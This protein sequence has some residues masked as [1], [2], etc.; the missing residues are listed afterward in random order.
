MKRLTTSIF[1]MTLLFISLHAQTD[2][3]I[4]YLNSDFETPDDQQNWQSLPV[5]NSIKWIYATGGNGFEP[6]SAYSGSKNALFYWSANDPYIRTLVSKAIDLSSAKKPELSFAHAMSESVFGQDNMVLLFRA[7]STG[8]WDT[9]EKFTQEVPNWTL[10]TY[11]I[12][13]Y[14]TKYLTSQFY[15]AFK[16][17]SNSGDGVCV[18]KVM[19][20]EKDII[21]RYPKTV[22]VNQINHSLIPR[23]V[24]DIPL[25]RIDINIV[26]NTDPAT[27]K[28]LVFKSLSSHDSLFAANG[29]ELVAT[30]D[31]VYKPTALGGASYK[32]GSPT[33]ITSGTVTFTNINFNLPT[34]MSSIWL[35][36]D[37]KSTAPHS[38]IVDFRM[39]GNSILINTSSGANY[40]PS[41]PVSPSGVNHVEEAIVLSDFETG[42][43]GWTFTGPQ[44]DFEIAIPMGKVAHISR[45]PDCA[46]SG[47]KVLGTDL[48]GDGKYLANIDNATAYYA[49]SPVANLKYYANVKLY[50]MKWLSFEAN[51]HAV[52]EVSTD[53]AKT[54]IKIWDSKTEALIPDT[55]W[56]EHTFSKNF[57]DLAARKPWVQVRFGI[58]SSDNSF[59]YA[60]WNIDNFA[61]T[62]NF[63]SN[64]IGITTLIKPVNDCLNPGY[65]SVVITV[66]NFAPYPTAATLPVFFSIDGTTRINDNIPG[67]IPVDGAV[68]FTFSRPANISTPNLYNKFIVDLEVSGDEDPSNDTIGRDLFIQNSLGVPSFEKFETGGGYWFPGGSSPTWECILPE[69]GGFPPIPQSPKAWTL[70]PYGNYI[71][72]DTSYVISSCYDLISEDSLLYEMKLWIDSEEGKD[73][74]AVEY[75]VDE[76]NTWRLLGNNIHGWNWNWYNVTVSSLG[77]PG[78]SAQ[79]A[80]WKTVR[81]VLPAFLNYEPKVKFRVKWASDDDNNYRGVAFDDVRIYNA[82]IDIGVSHIDSFANRCQ[83]LNPEEVTVVVKNFGLNSLKQNDTIIVAY[84]FNLLKVETDTFKLA[85]DLLPGQSI[86]HTF[87]TRIETLNPG[88][89]HIRAYTLSEN[90]PWFYGDN[91]DSV[92]VSFSVFPNPVTSLIDTIQTHLPDTVILVTTPNSTYDYWWNG[93]SGSNTYNV[94]RDGWQYLKVT[95]TRG[96]GCTS[97]DSTNVELLFHDIGTD[98]LLHPVDNCGFGKHEYPVV[99]VRNFGTDSITAGQ[100]IVVVYQMNGEVPVSDTIT[101]GSTLHSG[102][103]VNFTFNKGAIDLSGAGTYNFKIYTSYG[104]DTIAVND[105]ITRSVV[106]LGRP[107]VSLGSD[108]TVEALSHTLDAGSGYESYLWDNNVTTRTREVTESGSYWVQVFDNK[109]CDNFDTAYVRLKIRDIS[110][111]GFNSPVSACTFN[112]SEP[113]SLKIYN[114]GTDTIASGTSIAVSYR[115]EEGTRINGNTTLVQQLLPGSFVLYTFGGTVDMSNQGDFSM[116][117]TAKIAGDLRTSNDTSLVTIYRY[118]GPSI[119]FGL[120]ETEYVE[121]VSLVIDAGYSPYYS[122]QWQDTVTTHSYTATTSGLFHVKA[123]DIRTQCFDR[124]TVMVFLIYGDVGITWS[125]MPTEGCAGTYENV[126]VRVQNLGPSVIGSS[127][128]IYVACD[129]NGTRVTIDTLVRTGN[130]NPGATLEMQ[131]SGS[132]PVMSAGMSS[133]R[134]Y[135]MYNK[136]K[137]PENDTLTIGFDAL[138][139]PEVNFGDVDG[140]L[141]VD[142]PH[143]LDAGAGHKSY[144]WQDNSTG[145]TYSVSVKGIYSVTVTG[146]NDCQTKKTV[147]INMPLGV[148]E[149]SRGVISLYPNPNQGLFNVVIDNKDQEELTVRIIN[150]QG[151]LVYIKELSAQQL[152]GE[153]IDVQYL[154]RGIYHILIQTKKEIYQGKMV[155]E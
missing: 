85:T 74:A 133:I 144:L 145:Q 65:D 91:N 52:I 13:D 127:A 147:R 155:I 129:V 27:L 108:I 40:Y 95:A 81:Q 118:P 109:G 96:N 138:P 113:V 44:N 62:G 139:A 134:M 154:S 79:T 6:P 150:N 46:Y 58:I 51:D 14:G 19:I 149:Y 8:T 47:T 102:K 146:Q 83:G 49:V 15:I 25:M 76:G 57:N 33:T 135:T 32:I 17:I 92:S 45:D 153:Q 84:D 16:G 151:Q 56:V 1:G 128:P 68:T 31:S 110:P 20:E 122:Y 121:D 107:E 90:D 18:D 131:L 124:D 63:L 143:V 123:T 88:N 36:A 28:S 43:Q 39:D 60:G 103:V 114:S 87:H 3:I 11:N 71:S 21:V 41:I 100:K 48:T 120:E 148:D 104:G 72:N 7:G 5:D 69:G 106:M 82:P 54:W 53:T 55:K 37:I 98:E 94:S 12:K 137:K 97:Y 10:R 117:A 59:S 115:L 99:R 61:I 9:I 70:S 78:W 75:S 130:F 125:D 101:L 34:G 126:G 116:E 42:S 112:A 50:F 80:G 141:N 152:S 4:R 23:G 77:T 93:T 86:K 35:V 22:S 66:R 64:D 136:D 2:T 142:L 30:R 24:K 26:G 111:G 105:T 73:G 38:G 89:Y 29:F 140:S 67:P 132:L 119:D